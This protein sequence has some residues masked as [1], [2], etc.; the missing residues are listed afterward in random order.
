MT[1]RGQSE[2][3]GFVLVF[4]LVIST[5]AIASVAGFGGLQD[6]RDFERTNNAKLAVDALARSLEEVAVAGAPSRV[7]DLSADAAQ[8]TVADPI[9][10]TVALENGSTHE[11]AVHPIVYEGPDDTRLVYAAGAVIRADDGGAV[12]L[13]EPR[14]VLS[15]NRSVV[16]VVRTYPRDSIGVGGNTVS[17][18]AEAEQ[19]SL[20]VANATPQDVTLAIESPRAAAWERGLASNTD[21]DCTTTGD[22]ATCSVTTDAVYVTVSDVAISLT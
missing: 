8:V 7:V 20:V 10:V 18:R 6:A 13:R 16:T 3:V 12:M 21:L 1:D 22:V 14:F 15:E 5:V 11:F 4:G 17:I 9:T 19:E 2:V